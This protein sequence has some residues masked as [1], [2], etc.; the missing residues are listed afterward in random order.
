MR[1]WVEYECKAMSDSKADALASALGQ[2]AGKRDNKELAGW[3]AGRLNVRK[4]R[5][6]QSKGNECWEWRCLE[7]RGK[8]KWAA[9]LMGEAA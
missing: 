7:W 9:G 5:G 3:Q 2:G 4:T 6:G 1:C 8:I